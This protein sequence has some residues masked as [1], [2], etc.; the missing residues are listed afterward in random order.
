ML[1]LTDED[2]MAWVDGEMP[3]DLAAKVSSIVDADPSLRERAESL[4]RL[5]HQLRTAF[6]SELAE[7]VPAA[8]M[9]QAMGHKPPAGGTVVPL[10]ARPRARGWAQ[11]GGIAASV[12]LLV[13][14]AYRLQPGRDA[15]TPLLAQ[16]GGQLR[17]NGPLADALE[18]GLASEAQGP[19]IRLLVSFRDRE[20]RYCRS[21]SSSAGRGLACRDTHHWQVVAL[22]APAAAASA[23]LR[24]AGDD[25]PEVVMQEVERRMAAPALDAQQERAARDA[26]WAP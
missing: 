5:N 3:D 24:L 13:G 10:P 20:G 14:L 21:F 12:L 17:A 9:A 18:R 6:A 16:T 22:A 25:W 8:L 7:P 11:W 1:R 15:E 23:D 4:Q 19:G 26:K 2:L